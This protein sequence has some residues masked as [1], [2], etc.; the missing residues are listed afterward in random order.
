KNV[1][2]HVTDEFQ[3]VYKAKDENQA[4]EKELTA[5]LAKL[6]KSRQKYMDM[7]TDDLI[8][9]Q[10]LN[11]RIGGMRQE[12]ERIE[13]ELKLISYNLTKREQLEQLLSRTFRELENVADVREMT[14]AQMHRIIEKIEVDS[15]G[16]VDIF[17]RIIGD[18]GLDKTVLISENRT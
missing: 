14:N 17:L 18:L 6:Q 5:R 11:E 4:Y 15:A 8:S 3:R 9:R 16:N 7:Y 13:N 1:I 12:I 2:R 10:E